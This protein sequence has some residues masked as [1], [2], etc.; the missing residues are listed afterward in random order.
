MHVW[1]CLWMTTR[2]R[3]PSW[4]KELYPLVS[5]MQ[6][7]ELD[8]LM[9]NLHVTDNNGFICCSLCNAPSNIM[10]DGLFRCRGCKCAYYCSN[11][12][13]SAHWLQG[14]HRSLCKRIR[15]LKNKRRKEDKKKASQKRRSKQRQEV[16]EE[17]LLHYSRS[18]TPG[19]LPVMIDRSSPETEQQENRVWKV[20][21]EWG[22]ILGIMLV[23]LWN[24]SWI[25][26]NV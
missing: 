22:I 17:D 23:Y 5:E 18:S 13:Q 21:R 19:S 16:E 15:L 14:N 26:L 6:L 9:A 11:E 10:P 12:C 3:Y 25:F 8:L 2:W 7:A 20:E 1:Y 24:N 4:A